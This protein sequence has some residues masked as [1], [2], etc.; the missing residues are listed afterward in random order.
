M[1]PPATLNEVFDFDLSFKKALKEYRDVLGE[2]LY[3]AASRT[4]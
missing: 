2:H 1:L 3:I 4:Y